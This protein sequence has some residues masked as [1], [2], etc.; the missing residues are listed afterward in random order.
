[1]SLQHTTGVPRGPRLRG[2][3]ALAAVGALALSGLAL[4]TVT[5]TAQTSGQTSG[6]TSSRTS[7]LAKPADAAA[8]RFGRMATYP[9]FLNV[10]EGV[11][12]L[13]ETVA[14]ISAVSED[15]ETVV[16]TDAA[17][18]RIGFLDISDPSAP[19]GLGTLDLSELG[20]AEDEPTSVAVVGD[21]VLVVV[22]TSPSYT[23]PSGRVDVVDLETRE[24][25]ASHDLGGQPDSI[26]VS[27]SGEYAAI[28][29]ENERDEDALP[30]GA[31]DDADEG[32][33]PQ[34]PAGFVQVLELDGA[35]ATWTPDP[36][37]LPAEDLAG[38]DTPEDPEP[39]Y[40]DINADD[41]LVV[42]LQENNGLVVV[43]LPTR[44]I[45]SAFSAGNVVLEGVDTTDD[46]VFN[47]TDTIDVPREPDAVHW[48]G[49]GLVATANEGDWKGGSRGWTVFEA[50]TGE[51]VW[52]AG[53]SFE[54]LVLSVGSFN[55]GRA[56]NKGAEPEGLTYAEYD[57][58]PYAF[59][60]S[61]RSNLVAV[62]D[63]TDPTEPA[64]TQVLPT[65]NGPE[66][67][68]PIPSR[69][70][71][72]VSSE[73]DDSDVGV[74][75]SVA[76]F[77]LG[78]DGVVW[79]DIVSVPAPGEDRPI[80]WGA[81][82]ALSGDQHDPKGLWSASDSA[83]SPARIYHLDV[84]AVPAVLDD[85]I[86]VT[87][88]GEPVDLD[89]EGIAERTQGGFWLASEGATGPENALV[90][91]DA[92]GVVVETVTLPTEVAA[93]LGKWGLEGV[94]VRGSGASETVYVALQRPL[95]GEDTARIGRYDVAEAAWTW[96]AYPMETTSTEG[97]WI[98]LSEITVIDRDT[99]AVIERDKLMGPAAAV[100][101]IY[102]V[103]LPAGS[104]DEVTP[105]TKTLAV[106][107][108]PAMTG[109]N[110][111]TQEKLEGLAVTTRGRVY[112]VTDN[113]GVDDAS[114][115]TQLFDLGRLS[116]VFAE[117]VA[118]TTKLKVKGRSRRAG[119]AFRVVVVVKPAPQGG[120]VVVEVDGQKVAS[121]RVD[122]RTTPL[123][124]RIKGTGEHTLTA[125]YTGNGLAAGS[126]S[127]TVT[128]KVKKAKKDQ[129]KR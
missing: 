28:A 37:L 110:G 116:S 38:M 89:I 52:D 78:T 79:P 8:E 10:P 26:A 58:V 117:D 51:V 108:L 104:A 99:V 100:K 12:P 19:E 33:L 45:T 125:T 127:K 123:R 62:Y 9:V 92:D 18:K 64:L 66:G 103:D 70:L 69:D 68:L 80:G 102:T 49:D 93:G 86:E 124:V 59:V 39:E 35:P 43:D 20:D 48:V 40:V 44:E 115:E 129:K 73:V 105:V 30:D 87:D 122:G 27:P 42:S 32:D 31:G 81:L 72:V 55:D 113:D 6:Q 119:Q 34:A 46:G 61:E 109:R 101:R 21:H 63:M 13:D 25:V 90:R 3:L 29:M 83:Y 94:A 121:T 76:L 1:M 98:G 15:G 128:V 56:D 85:V 24:L 57:G 54:D 16:Y 118:T 22:N 106:D 120:R 74:R 111:W 47:A 5:S 2:G 96:F 71:L 84:S 50:A 97:D 114:G 77:E 126:T 107:L 14:E 67:L 95:T 88:G 36:L 82:G 112:A 53:T 4:G 75:A 91:T 11:D 23:E 41:E 7:T 17:G 65:T 60:G